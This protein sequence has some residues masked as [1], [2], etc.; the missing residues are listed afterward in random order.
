MLEVYGAKLLRY[1]GILYLVDDPY[2]T[3]IQGVHMLM[4]GDTG[5]AWK[6]DEKRESVLVFIGRNLPKLSILEGLQLCLV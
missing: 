5:S 3:V 4:G 1:K 6:A 2:K